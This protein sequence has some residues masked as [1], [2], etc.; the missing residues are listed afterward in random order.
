MKMEIHNKIKYFIVG[1]LV[2]F[3]VMN[4]VS[5]ALAGGDQDPLVTVGY[6]ENRFS[7]FNKF[8]SL[9]IEEALGNVSASDVTKFEVIHLN[10]SDVIYLGDSTEFILRSGEATAIT[11]ESGGIADLT[12]GVDIKY[13]ELIPLNHHLLVPAN[14]G[15]GL[16]CSTEAYALVKGS[17][18]VS[19]NNN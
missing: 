13:G 12:T 19:T 1:V 8:V 17:Y 11:T 18:Q 3:F 2:A 14:D 5:L 9:K 15:R 10:P 4:G 6:V 16:T 7:E